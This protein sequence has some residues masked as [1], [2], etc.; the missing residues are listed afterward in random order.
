LLSLAIQNTQVN[1]LD[2][3]NKSPAPWNNTFYSNSFRRGTIINKHG[4]EA[5]VRI[6]NLEK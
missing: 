4:S 3:W 2:L 1:N 5:G 6:K